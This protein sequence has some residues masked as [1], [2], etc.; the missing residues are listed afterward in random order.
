MVLTD[1]GWVYEIFINLRVV[2]I[3]WVYTQGVI[4]MR[5]EIKF[6]PAGEGTVLPFNYNYDVYTQI[7]QKISLVSP[8]L[9]YDV[10]SS[11]VDQFTFSRI[12][13]R[14]RE[15]IPEKGIR[16][17]SDDVSLYFSSSNTELIKA[18]VEGFVED[19]VL[20][21][22]EATLMAENVKVLRE[23]RIKERMLFSTLS[24]VMVRTVKLDGEQMKIWDLYP[25]DE[26]F[27]EKLRKVMLTRYLAIFGDMPSDRDFSLEVIKFKPVR[28]VVKDMYYRG[29]LMIFRYEG[30][31]E[32]AKFGY[33]NGFGEKT[34]YGFGMVKVIDER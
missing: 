12:M 16:I 24:P 15:L 10:D 7:I 18:V 9:A 22:G 25:S 4:I 21:V 31:V 20:R 33:E 11:H 14:K 3:K 29:S 5:I 23:P 1:G 17:L 2:L 30:S 6:R 19:P 34:R 27:F 28:I 26:L 8:E 13:V 32:I